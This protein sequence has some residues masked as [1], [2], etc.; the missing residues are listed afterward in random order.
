MR[1]GDYK[2][3]QNYFVPVGFRSEPPYC[4]SIHPYFDRIY[5][6]EK[7]DSEQNKIYRFMPTFYTRIYEKIGKKE[8]LVPRYDCFYV[9]TAHPK[10]Y[11]EINRMAED[12][13]AGTAKAVY[14]SLYSVGF[15]IRIS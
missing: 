6:F 11:L 10:K 12:L 7:A 15:E 8:R 1:C 9:G 5:T 4:K 14:I 3:R 13:K 2:S